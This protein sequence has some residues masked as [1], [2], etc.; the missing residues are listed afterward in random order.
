MIAGTDLRGVLRRRVP[1]SVPGLPDHARRPGRGLV[2]HH[3]RRH[4]RPAGAT[5]PTPTSTTPAAGTATSGGCRWLTMIVATGIGWGLVTNTPASWLT[6]QGYLLEPLGLGGKEGDWAFANLGVLFALVAGFLVQLVRRRR[7]AVRQVRRRWPDGT[8]LALIDLQRIFAEPGLAAGPRRT[9][10]G[11]SKPT[12]EL[13]ELFSPQVSSP[14]SWRRSSRPVPG[15]RT[16]RSSRSPCSHRTPTTT[17]WWTSS[18]ALRHSTSR[19]SASGAPSSPRRSG[20]GGQ[21]VLGGVTT[22]CCVITTA[23][24]AVDAGVHVQVVE[25]ACAGSTRTRPSEGDRHHAAVLA[26]AGDRQRRPVPRADRAAPMLRDRLKHERI[27][28]ILARE[29]RSGVGTARCPAAR[30]GRA[31]ASG[32][33]SAGTRSGLGARRTDR[34]RVDHHPDRQGVVRV[35][36]R[37]AAGR[38]ARLD[39]RAGR[40]GRRDPDADA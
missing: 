35:V 6:W 13:V 38:P 34:G 17:N 32:S 12:Q 37:A 29:I 9:S 19:R 10:S 23:L 27:A 28:A 25:D 16:T 11:W 21:L 24:A 39:P 40:T 22:D 33:R 36:R 30:G 31:G 3:A 1:R 18:R 26:D 14:G 4:R 2:R 7:C 5:T 8:V 20:R 15:C